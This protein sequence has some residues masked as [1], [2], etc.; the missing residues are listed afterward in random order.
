MTQP[1]IE[2]SS[3]DGTSRSGGHHTEQTAR[4]T[5]RCPAVSSSRWPSVAEPALLYP[6]PMTQSRAL[7]GGG[8]GREENAPP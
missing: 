4:P 8:G 5:P 3:L 1:Y 7:G 2:A 6:D